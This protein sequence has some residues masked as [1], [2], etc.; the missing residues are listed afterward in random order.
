VKRKTI[1]ELEDKVAG[2]QPY[3]EATICLQRMMIQDDSVLIESG[4]LGE[5]EYR[6]I[7]V[8]GLDRWSGGVVLWINGEACAAEWLTDLTSRWSRSGDPY[9]A[10]V[11]HKAQRALQAAVERR[12]ARKAG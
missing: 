3:V 5:E 1:K 9:E 7:R 11:A 12:H 8:V 4:V 10:D 6:S 2:L